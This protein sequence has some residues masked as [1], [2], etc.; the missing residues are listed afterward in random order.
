MPSSNQSDHFQKESIDFGITKEDRWK[1]KLEDWKMTKERIS[2]FD[3]TAVKIRLTGIP[4]ILIIIGIGFSLIDKSIGI[5][6]PIIDCSAA[7]LPFIFAMLYIIPLACL[8]YVHYKLLLHAVKHA[9]MIEESPEFNGLLGVT[10]AITIKK[11][12][13]IHTFCAVLIYVLIFGM[14][15]ILAYTFWNGPVTDPSSTNYQINQTTNLTSDQKTSQNHISNKQSN[16]NFEKQSSI[17]TEFTNIRGGNIFKH[18][19]QTPPPP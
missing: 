15:L 12:E 4:I 9:Q 3:N 17:L 7:A 1:I 14:C 16:S 19:S 8:D 2:N 11:I 10:K 6:V 5:R 13:Y 18:P